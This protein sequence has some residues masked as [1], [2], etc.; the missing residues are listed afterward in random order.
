M[1][2]E[3]PSQLRSLLGDTF[4]YSDVVR[5]GLQGQW[6]RDL[7]DLGEIL[8]LDRGVYRWAAAPSADHDLIGISE[9]FPEA[10]ICLES[11][12]AR[13]RLIEE[14]PPAIDIALPRGGTRPKFRAPVR[15]HQFDP[16]TFSIA[17]ELLLPT[18]GRTPV[19]IYSAERTLI[20]MI[21]VRRRTV[22]DVPREALRRWLDQPGNTAGQLIDLAWRL[23]RAETA[24]RAALQSVQ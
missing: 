21:R 11:A 18:G 1:R 12:L 20:D 5:E 2:V 17:R 9:R 19:G 14:T 8:H 7:R 13:H 22:S 6:L 4:T 15:L 23:P 10:T 24:L 3:D 16:L